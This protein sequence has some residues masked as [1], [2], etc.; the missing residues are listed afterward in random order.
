MSDYRFRTNWR[1]KLILQRRYYYRN[2]WGDRCHYWCDAKTE[3]LRDYYEKHTQ[4][5]V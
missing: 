5:S 2:S 4:S 3:D 1:G